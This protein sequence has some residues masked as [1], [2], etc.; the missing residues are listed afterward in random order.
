VER[1]TASLFAIATLVRLTHCTS[2]GAANVLNAQRHRCVCKDIEK[3]DREVDNR[4]RSRSTHS[5]GWL[6]VPC[7]VRQ[8][9]KTLIELIDRFL[10]H[11]PKARSLCRE[12]G[13]GR[14]GALGYLWDKL[15]VK[16][17]DA[18]RQPRNWVRCNGLGH[19]RNY[20]NREC[21][22][23]MYAKGGCTVKRKRHD[24]SEID[25]PD[26][27]TECD[28]LSALERS[29][30]VAA[31]QA[32]LDRQPEKKRE[33]LLAHL[34][35]HPDHLSLRDVAKRYGKSPEAVRKWA[36]AVRQQ[37]TYQLEVFR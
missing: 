21:R 23:G 6:A 25:A 15:R 34:K 36:I 31:V 2:R 33:A 4:V 24:L 35:I 7:E 10:E 14:K 3:V 18:I 32:N 22:Y 8:I 13:E 16:F 11:D 1:L 12:F 20:L 9:N 37:L 5:A 29:E 26:E 28:G 19:L 30:I 27:R 17:S